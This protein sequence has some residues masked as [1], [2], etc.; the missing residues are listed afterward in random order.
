MG[1]TPG[2]EIAV[3]KIAPFGD[4]IEVNLRGYDLSLRRDDAAQIALGEVRKA[5][6]RTATG[7]TTYHTRR[8]DPETLRRMRDGPRT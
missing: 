4:P 2:T 3:K 8:L 1:L 6:C 7:V 5:S